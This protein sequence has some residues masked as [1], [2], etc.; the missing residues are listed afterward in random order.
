MLCLGNHSCQLE[1][2]REGGCGEPREWEGGGVGVLLAVWSS[3]PA[4]NCGKPALRIIAPAS[5]ATIKRSPREAGILG[6]ELFVILGQAA[7]IYCRWVCE[8]EF[9]QSET[10]TGEMETANSQGVVFGKI[11]S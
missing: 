4:G 3:S 9:C 5:S 11:R 2:G 6:G 7:V 1:G 10:G 8:V